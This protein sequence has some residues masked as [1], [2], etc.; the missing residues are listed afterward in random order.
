M[1][2][3]QQGLTNDKFFSLLHLPARKTQGKKSLVDYFQSHV[4][5]LE[6]YLNRLRS[7]ALKKEASK[8]IKET[9]KKERLKKQAKRVG[10][11][12]IVIER[13]AHRELEKQ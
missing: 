13:F 4:V 6:E 12:L 5:N 7:K 9:Q 10:S 8:T 11:S 1:N 2:T 3:I